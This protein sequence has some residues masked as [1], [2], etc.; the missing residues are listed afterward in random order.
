VSRANYWCESLSESFSEHGITASQEQIAA[1]ARDIEHIRDGESLA[2]HT[3]ENPMIE[4]N[5][6]LE[7]KLKREQSA[8]FC[9]AC[10]GSGRDRHMAGP[11]FVDTE[12][13]DCRGAGRLYS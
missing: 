2:F 8:R 6:E 12:C 3:P 1:V 13:S 5:K 9:K 4:R 10:A 11:W 7:K